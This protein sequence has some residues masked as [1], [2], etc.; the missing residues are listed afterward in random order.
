MNLLKSDNFNIFRCKFLIVIYN[1][2]LKGICK[3]EKTKGERET[4]RKK[5]KYIKYVDAVFKKGQW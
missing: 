2:E 3:G 1:L 4:K 5:E